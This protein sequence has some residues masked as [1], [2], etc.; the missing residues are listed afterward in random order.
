MADVANFVTQNFRAPLRADVDRTKYSNAL[1]RNEVDR[2]PQQ[3]RMQDLQ[4]QSQDMQITEQQKKNAVGVLGRNFALAAQSR[5][6]SQAYR[7]LISSP[8]FQ[9]AGKVAGLPVDQF[10][11]DPATDNDDSVRQ[12]LQ[13]WADTLSGVRPKEVSPTDDQ[14]EY[15]QAVQQGFRGTIVD[16]LTQMRRAGA[17]SI[18]MRSPPAAP[19]GMTYVPDQDPSNKLGYRLVPIP[20]ARDPRTEAQQKAGLLSARMR[21]LS[22]DV[23]DTAPTIPTQMIASIAQGG[24][25]T[26]GLANQ[27]LTPEQQKHF[28]AARGW[29]AGVLRQDTGATIQPFEIAE[30]YPTFFPVPGDSPQVIEQKRKLRAVTEQAISANGGMQQQPAAQGMPDFSQMSDEQLQQIINGQ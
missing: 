24:G 8:D 25:M 21:E 5:S 12:Q 16:Y 7:T 14:R 30:Y 11:Y 27:A 23:V 28:N 13:A 18:D 10:T 26:G 17:T 22:A 29:L 20:G 3:N 4:I 1:L 6:P 9:A 19:Q 15:E 2:L